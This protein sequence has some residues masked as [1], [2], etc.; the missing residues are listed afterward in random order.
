MFVRHLGQRPDSYLSG[1]TETFWTKRL[2]AWHRGAADK[3]QPEPITARATFHKDPTNDHDAG[4]F[5]KSRLLLLISM[6]D[7]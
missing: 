3:R 4:T 5:R 1:A 2:S 6:D 7:L